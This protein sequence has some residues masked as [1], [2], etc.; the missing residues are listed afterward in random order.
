MSALVLVLA[1]L[2][3]A[4]VGLALC[5]LG[6]KARRD[7]SE[8]RS[9]VRRARL[10]AAIEAGEQAPLTAALVG[11]RSSQEDAIAALRAMGRRP[12]GQQVPPELLVQLRSRRVARRGRA[13]VLLGLLGASGAAGEVARCLF[14]SDPDVRLAAAN[15]LEGFAEPACARHLVDAFEAGMLQGSRVVERISHGWAVLSLVEVRERLAPAARALLWRACGLTGARFTVPLLRETLAQG[16]DEERI[17]AARA[18]GEIG[19]TEAGLDLVEALDDPIWEVRAQ[20][21]TALGRVGDATAVEPLVEATSDSA[22]W[23]R[24]NAATALA[25]M[26]TRGAL[27][28]EKVRSGGDRYAAERAAEALEGIVA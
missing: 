23:V 19:A 1:V 21:A 25:G 18:L 13:I 5:T 2:A 3:T 9:Q 26:G 12:S 4:L 24:A 10:R 7:A 20:A 17:C 22:W 14:D 8:R 27:A 28:L 15:A 16:E 6:R 11:R